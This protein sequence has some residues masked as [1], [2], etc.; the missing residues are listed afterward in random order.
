MA[1]VEDGQLRGAFRR[2]HNRDPIF[3]FSGG[4]KWRQ[5]EY[6]YQYQYEYMPRAKVVDEGGRY[7]LYVEGMD[8]PVEVKRLG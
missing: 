8:E 2:F 6:K 7:L 3:E 1:V 5:D 4:G